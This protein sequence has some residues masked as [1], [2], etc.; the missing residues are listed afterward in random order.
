MQ[1]L[2]DAEHGVIAEA[3]RFLTAV[4]RDRLIR[5]SSVLAAARKVGPDQHSALA[6]S[7]PLPLSV[8]SVYLSSSSPRHLLQ[9]VRTGWLLL[10]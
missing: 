5:K 7:P 3:V 1:A 4:C 10:D 8:P 2:A 9:H 6:L